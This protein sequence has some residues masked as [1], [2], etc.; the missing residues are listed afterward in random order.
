M[1][2]LYKFIFHPK[3]KKDSQISLCYRDYRNVII[4]F[5]YYR[6]FTSSKYIAKCLYYPASCLSI[7]VSWYLCHLSTLSSSLSIDFS[8]F[9]T[10]SLSL[11]IKTIA[12]NFDN[13]PT[14]ISTTNHINHNYSPMRYPL[15]LIKT[16]NT[17]RNLIMRKPQPRKLSLSMRWKLC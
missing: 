10:L 7:Y 11:S 8:L 14:H 6:L 9:L 1:F 5:I 13:S 16:L 4:I 12:Y 3:T 2:V 17:S 15:M